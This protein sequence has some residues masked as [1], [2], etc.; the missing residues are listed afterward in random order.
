MARKTAPYFQNF[1]G[2]ETFLV[3]DLERD[4][5]LGNTYE[6]GIDVWQLVKCTTT[7]TAKDLLFWSDKKK[8]EVSTT[9]VNNEPAGVAEISVAS[10]NS[11]IWIK[12]RGQKSTKADD[13]TLAAGQEVIADSASNRVTA[14][15]GLLTGAL[16]AVDTGGGVFSVASAFTEDVFVDFVSITRSTKSSGACTVD[17]GV[18]LTSA[19]TLSDN[20]M[21]G[22]NAAASEATENNFAN[23]GTNGKVRQIWPAGKWVTASV[24]SGN[25]AGLVGTYAIRY[26]H[27][28]KRKVIGTA[29]GAVS[30]GFVTVDLQL[31][32]A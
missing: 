20:L 5:E 19:T 2:P 21:D 10:A 9:H 12:L 25:S 4:G 13:V 22:V 16:A 29:Q 31:D 3:A 11:Y 32:P 24:A 14:R 26:S 8:F 7:A 28:S 15:S 1:S 30:G 6:R 27:T 23:A 17:V 18:T